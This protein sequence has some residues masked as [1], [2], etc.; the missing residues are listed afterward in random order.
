MFGGLLL[1]GKGCMDK[2]MKSFIV[3][4]MVQKGDCR[5]PVDNSLLATRKVLALSPKPS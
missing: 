3:L 5:D 2:K 1:V 4:E